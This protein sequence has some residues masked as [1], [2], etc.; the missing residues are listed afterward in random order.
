MPGVVHEPD[1]V[2]LFQRCP[3]AGGDE[4]LRDR[5]APTPGVD[6]EVGVHL[7]AALGGHPDDAGDPAGG[8]GGREQA[9]HPDTAADLQPGLGGGE[10]GQRAFDHRTTSGQRGEAFVARSDPA[11]HGL[12]QGQHAV[13]AICTVGHECGA[14]V[15]QFGVEVLPEPGQEGVQQPELGDATALPA[16]PPFVG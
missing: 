5:R 6:D 9:T 16:V 15:G 2:A 1:V 11:G 3:A 8:P 10:P 4:P 14:D 13:E 7:V 12:G